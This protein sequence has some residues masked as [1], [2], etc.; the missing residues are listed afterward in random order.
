MVYISLLQLRVRRIRLHVRQ[1]T[2]AQIP[3]TLMLTTF[4]VHVSY[5]FILC[6]LCLRLW[7]GDKLM[8][9]QV[10]YTCLLSLHIIHQ[11]ICFIH[12]KIKFVVTFQ[13][14][15][16][17]DPV[18]Q[19]TR[20]RIQKLHPLKETTILAQV[21]HSNM[22]YLFLHIKILNIAGIF[23]SIFISNIYFLLLVY[24]IYFIALQL[25]FGIHKLMVQIIKQKDFS[26]HQ[27]SFQIHVVLTLVMSVMNASIH[28][29]Q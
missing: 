26:N 22:Q 20:A 11:P 15:V 23:I 28:L 4:T 2:L 7:R 24:E 6:Y 29:L 27:H 3:T 17:Q 13:L 25:T 12:L 18:P 21:L 9:L 19:D 8:P 10:G 1:D 16:M 5:R 14:L